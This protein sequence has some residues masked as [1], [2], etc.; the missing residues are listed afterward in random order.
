MNRCRLELTDANFKQ[1]VLD[2][3]VPVLVDFWGS[4]CPPCKMVEPVVDELATEFDGRLKV[5]KLNVDLN[6]RTATMFNI[7]GA[8]TF[9][10]FERGKPIRREVGARSK[11]QLLQVIEDSLARRHAQPPIKVSALNTT[12]KT[13]PAAKAEKVRKSSGK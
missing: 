5:Y 8:P 11:K 2:R 12:T 10:L 6:P 9:I 7:S 4:W 13:G 1:K 3:D